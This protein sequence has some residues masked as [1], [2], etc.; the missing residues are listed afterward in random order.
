LDC[1]G[2]S[3]A[4]QVLGVEQAP[5]GKAIDEATIMVAAEYASDGGDPLSDLHTSGDYRLTLA[6]VYTK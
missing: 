3:S 2:C 1:G 6:R 4:A 5:E